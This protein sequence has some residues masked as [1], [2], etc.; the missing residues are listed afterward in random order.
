MFDVSG[1]GDYPSDGAWVSTLRAHMG[2]VYAL[3]LGSECLLTGGDDGCVFEWAR[4]PAR[5][6]GWG[7]AA[8]QE[9]DCEEEL[10]EEEPAPVAKLEMSSWRRAQAAGEA[11]GAAAETRGLGSRGGEGGRASITAL[12]GLGAGPEGF[13]AGTWE[14]HVVRASRGRGRI[15]G[16]GTALTRQEASG[17]SVEVPVTALAA[18]LQVV[19]VGGQ[20]GEVR[21]LRMLSEE[22]EEEE[23]EDE[24]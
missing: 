5:F 8:A 11:S 1:G 16:F 14:G 17:V 10:M 15:R 9:G 20:F 7:G 13:L 24:V 6:R 19:A 3:A 2:D 4:A 21:F 12:V 18:S 22:E 23:E